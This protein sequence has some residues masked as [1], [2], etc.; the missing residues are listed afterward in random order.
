M[1][2]SGSHAANPKPHRSAMGSGS[3]ST[4]RRVTCNQ[5]YYYAIN[6]SS[7]KDVN[8]TG[9]MANFDDPA[10]EI[11]IQFIPES[12]RDIARFTQLN[13]AAMALVN[14]P[15]FRAFPVIAETARLSDEIYDSVI[16]G[17]FDSLEVEFEA[18]PRLISPDAARSVAPLLPVLGR[19]R[20]KDLTERIIKSTSGVAAA[21]MREVAPQLDH[22]DPEHGSALADRAVE[23]LSRKGSRFADER[24]DVVPMIAEARAGGHLSPL[25]DARVAFITGRNLHLRTAL[26]LEM[27]GRE[28][29]REIRWDQA[30]ANAT[31]AQADGVTIE[32]VKALRARFEEALTREDL[33]QPSNEIRSVTQAVAELGKF[34]SEQLLK[35]RRSKD[36]WERRGI[37]KRL[38]SREADLGR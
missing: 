23:I 25:N 10:Y 18:E 21:T 5:Q 4:T 15:E 6:N 8:E 30:R 31:N 19:S 27:V 37:D 36:D 12:S 17:R 32:Q 34:A 35:D 1:E 33:Q 7:D 38:R 3:G 20:K 14:A 28:I 2:C 13:R 24:R 9:V 29:E 16:K 11:K 26:S 22:F